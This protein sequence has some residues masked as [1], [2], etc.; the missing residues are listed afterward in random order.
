MLKL[1]INYTYAK[2]FEKKYRREKYTKFIQVYSGFFYS[3]NWCFSIRQEVIIIH[4]KLLTILTIFAPLLCDNNFMHFLKTCF[5]YFC[6]TWLCIFCNTCKFKKALSLQV[7]R[8][9]VNVNGNYLNCCTFDIIMYLL[10]DV[11]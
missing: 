6:I 2:Y 11:V 4:C 10:L 1:W 5:M 8:L 3:C 9:L 7:K